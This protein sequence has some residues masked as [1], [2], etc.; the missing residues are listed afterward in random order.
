MA[1]K[2]TY[3]LADKGMNLIEGSNIRD[4]LD[5][6]VESEEFITAIRE[7]MDGRKRRWGR[8]T[9]IMYHSEIA[10]E[11]GGL[12]TP[13]KIPYDP[14]EKLTEFS[15]EKG[16]PIDYVVALSAITTYI[17]ERFREKGIF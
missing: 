15:R 6:L 7:R 13:E 12:I 10:L 11:L 17:L 2:Q 14:V 1:S 3:T 5:G 8:V 16:T 9:E 4:V